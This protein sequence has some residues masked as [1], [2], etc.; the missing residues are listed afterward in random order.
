MERATARESR[1]P[2]PHWTVP[3]PET[4]M[5]P[6]R[7]FL[8]LASAVGA[9]TLLAAGPAPVRAGTARPGGVAFDAFALFDTRPLVALAEHL[10]PGKGTRLA[11]AWRARQFE[12]AWLR[13]AA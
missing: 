12:Y 1:W 5:L 11:D 4:P 9:A 6:R 8:D 13:V 2:D 3:K 7:S 10:F